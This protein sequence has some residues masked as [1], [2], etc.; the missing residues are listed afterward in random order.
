SSVRRHDHGDQD[1]AFIIDMEPATSPKTSKIEKI[2]S[3]WC[4]VRRKSVPGYPSSI[5]KHP[6]AEIKP[7][8]IGR[9][10]WYDQLLVDRSLRTMAALMTLFAIVMLIIVGVN[11]KAF[12]QRVN[13]YSSSIGS[14]SKNC[15]H[16][17]RMNTAL[18]FLINVAATMILGMSNTYQQLITSLKIDDLEHMLQKFGDSRVG[19]NSPLNI[20]HKVQGKK[21]SWVAWTFLIVTSLPVHFL[22]NSLI[23]PSIVMQPP[24]NVQLNEMTMNASMP[25]R[26]DLIYSDSFL[27]W[28]AFRT[29]TAHFG[30]KVMNLDTPGDVFSVATHIREGMTYG[31]FI[32]NYQ[33]DVCT[34]F[35]GTAVDVDALEE[36]EHYNDYS[37]LRY[38]VEFNPECNMSAAV[39]CSVHEP[40]PIACRLNVRMNAAFVL[41]GCLT[42]KAIY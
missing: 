31:K 8:R 7:A 20:N 11:M 38:G 19:T 26:E 13:R 42:S 37:F 16:I 3:G 9:G 27:C 4:R 35:I 34:G 2:K 23:G 41:L 24:S 39:Y 14:N 17:A 10:I 25:R 29:G 21:R 1:D 28:S 30:K 6:V 32:I 40:K 18:L 22:A 15:K 36:V 33:K 5:R 12:Q